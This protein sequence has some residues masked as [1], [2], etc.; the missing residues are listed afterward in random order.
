MNPPLI[1]DRDN[2]A[3]LCYLRTLVQ[4]ISFYTLQS[5][6]NS[7]Q[8]KQNHFL[9]IFSSLKTVFCYLVCTDWIL[10][11]GLAAPAPPPP[12]P[13]GPPPERLFGMKASDIDK[14]SRVVFPIAFLSFHLMYWMIYLTISNEVADDLVYLQMP[15]QSALQYLGPGKNIR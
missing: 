1:S 3:T 8:N 10:F 2:Q 15:E 6:S 7:N 11:V 12:P 5:T 9:G 4:F 13:P 14:Y